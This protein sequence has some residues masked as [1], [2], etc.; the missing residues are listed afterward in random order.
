VNTPELVYLIESVEVVSWSPSRE[1]IDRYPC[2]ATQVHVLLT[3]R[4]IG[5]PLALRLKSPAA[6]DQLI[7]AL[8]EHRTFVWGKVE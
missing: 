8:Q 5:T 6:A 4:G 1:G 7:A 3:L 2:P